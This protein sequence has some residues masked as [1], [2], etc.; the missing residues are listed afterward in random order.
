[1]KGNQIIKQ[2]F[3]AN[4]EMQEYIMLQQPSIGEVVVGWLGIF[5]NR[6]LNAGTDELLSI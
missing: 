6:S 2:L 3:N 1:M 4:A 5:E